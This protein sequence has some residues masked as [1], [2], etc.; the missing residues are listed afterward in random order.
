VFRIGEFSKLT[1]VSIRMLR[2]YDDVGIL[3]PAKINNENGYRMY[4]VEQTKVLSKIIFLRDI[5]FST[6]EISHALK[7]WDSE[8]LKKEFRRKEEVIKEA[9]RIE[10]Q[11]LEKLRGAMWEIDDNKDFNYNVVIKSIPF[12]NVISIRKI[13]PNYFSEGEL[14]HLL[15]EHIKKENLNI[16]DSNHSFAIYHDNEY[17]EIDVDIEVCIVTEE[18]GIEKDG[19]SF[20]KTEAFDLVGATMVYGPYE[21]ISGAYKSFVNWFDEN[22]QYEIS[23]LS[24]QVCHKGPWNEKNPKNY[25]TEIQIPIRIKS[26]SKK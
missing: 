18:K 14:W 21:N 12:Y 15:C 13:V 26:Q 1:Q 20:R 16:K 6:E 22:N 5:G 3:K 2:Y 17:K 11:K 7:H 19:V 9:I 8:S 4:S 23:G 25:L 24:M 10:E